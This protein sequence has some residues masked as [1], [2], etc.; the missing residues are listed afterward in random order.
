MGLIQSTSIK[1]QAL[2]FWAVY[3]K[4]FFLK[5]GCRQMIIKYLLSERGEF[6]FLLLSLLFEGSEKGYSSWLVPTCFPRTFPPDKHAHQPAALNTAD[7]G[8]G[9]AWTVF[10]LQS[11]KGLS[12]QSSEQPWLAASSPQASPNLAAH[13]PF[14]LDELS[15][16]TRFFFHTGF[17]DFE[18]QGLNLAWG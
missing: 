4:I 13:C 8:K 11:A 12:P 16:K 2:A 5:I 1:I 6:F 10:S 7:T 14:L 18:G 17:I 15:R 3:L 9:P